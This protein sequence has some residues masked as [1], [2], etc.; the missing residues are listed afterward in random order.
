MDGSAINY[1]GAYIITV[2]T[3][4][5]YGKT[6]EVYIIFYFINIKLNINIILEYDWFAGSNFLIN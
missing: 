2:Q 5:I 1:Y 6:E 4:D 3:T